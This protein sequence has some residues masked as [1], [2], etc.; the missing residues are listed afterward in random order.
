MKV[1]PDFYVL[2]GA[3]YLFLSVPTIK[4]I[5]QDNWIAN[6]G[7]FLL[8]GN[9]IR[10]TSTTLL[11]LES[12]AYIVFD[13]TVFHLC[14][15]TATYLFFSNSLLII[16]VLFDLGKVDRESTIDQFQ[17]PSRKLTGLTLCKC[18]MIL[19]IYGLMLFEIDWH[20]ELIIDIIVILQCLTLILVT[21]YVMHL[22]RKP[23]FS[24]KRMVSSLK[25]KDTTYFI[26]KLYFYLIISICCF[27]IRIIEIIL[28]IFL[29]YSLIF[30]FIIYG[31]EIVTII[32]YLWSIPLEMKKRPKNI[33][34][35]L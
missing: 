25:I 33:Q 20:L 5:T 24:L 1:V 23:Y 9:L 15:V 17:D 7:I 3:V 32:F 19:S 18:L 10:M 30:H 11:F 28:S 13:N 26:H 22:D 21:V 4:M 34:I 14:E 16:S 27:S 29:D 6:S 2:F 31:C 35:E 12:S 8:L